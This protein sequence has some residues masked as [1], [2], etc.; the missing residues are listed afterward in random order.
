MI[1]YP[2]KSVCVVLGLGAAS[3]LL[4]AGCGPCGAPQPRV[5]KVDKRPPLEVVR[6][7]LEQYAAGQP[8]DSERDL[9]PG[10]VSDVR[11]IDPE[12]ADSIEQGL[13][14]IAADPAQARVIAKKI[15][16]KLP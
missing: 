16:E 9:F 8:V 14:Q 11:A 3:A 6:A 12:T 10:W 1:G 7:Q 4:L 5:I 2:A 13:R 15:L